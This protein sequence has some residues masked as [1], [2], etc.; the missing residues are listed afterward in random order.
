MNTS[1][2]N[3]AK[4]G[5]DWSSIIYV[6]GPQDKV[7]L[8]FEPPRLNPQWKFPGGEGEVGESP[9]QTALREL[10][11]EA[12]LIIHPSHDVVLLKVF[13]KGNHDLF[14]YYTT[15]A[16]FDDLPERGSNGELVRTFKRKEIDEM[17]D[18]LW[19]HRRYLKLVDL[20]ERNLGS[21]DRAC[22]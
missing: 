5:R 8:I 20:H 19:H 12:G 1:S 11:E 13:D 22:G 17:K 18:L 3:T 6:R 9:V 16:T 14:V 4:E 15:V 21:G 2:N 7:L 10:K